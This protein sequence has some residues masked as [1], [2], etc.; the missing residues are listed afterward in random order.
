VV[1][2]G[3]INRTAA[4]D[5]MIAFDQVRAMIW[6]LQLILTLRRLYLPSLSRLPETLSWTRVIQH[7]ESSIWVGGWAGNTPLR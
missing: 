3:S 5:A 1:T 2:S 7:P 4:G 6:W